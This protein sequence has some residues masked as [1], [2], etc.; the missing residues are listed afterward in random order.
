MSKGSLDK[1]LYRQNGN[2]DWSERFKII[3]DV[4]SGLCYLH[5]QWVQVIIYHT[6]LNLYLSSA[7]LGFRPRNPALSNCY[8]YSSMIN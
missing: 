5:Q 3:K 8:Q 2:L 6:S 7:A 4:A 1:F